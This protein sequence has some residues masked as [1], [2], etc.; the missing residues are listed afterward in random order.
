MR[1]RQRSSPAPVLLVLAAS[2]VLA[3]LPVRPGRAFVTSRRSRM[4]FAR[5]WRPGVRAVQRLR[6][7][8]AGGLVASMQDH[9][10][11]VVTADGA[12]LRKLTSSGGGDPA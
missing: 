2:L 5:H 3:L 1:R 4:T 12:G 6:I 10:L 11:C 8:R 7:Q 9:E